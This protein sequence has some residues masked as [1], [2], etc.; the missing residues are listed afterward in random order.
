M[1]IT[2]FAGASICLPTLE[3]FKL[4]RQPNGSQT[5]LS[6]AVPPVLCAHVEIVFSFEH[7]QQSVLVQ[8]DHEIFSLYPSPALL[9]IPCYLCKTIL[10]LSKCSSL[11]LSTFCIPL[12]AALF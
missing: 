7:G 9:I 10:K 11:P 8:G 4:R 1:T 2:D 6:L 3:L 5:N 12:E